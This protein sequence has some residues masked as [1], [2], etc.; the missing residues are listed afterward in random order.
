M[1]MMMMVMMMI[2]IMMNRL[3]HQ[4]DMLWLDMLS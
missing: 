4:I 1:M 3:N 2:M